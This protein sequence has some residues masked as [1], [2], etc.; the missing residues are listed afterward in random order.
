MK[1]QPQS[2]HPHGLSDKDFD[3]LFTNDKPIVFAFHGYPSLIHQ[4]TYRRTNHPNLHVR[5]YKEEGTTTT[6]F[7][8]TVMNDLDRFHLF[9]DVINR[10]PQLESHADR[11]RQF[12]RARLFDH[13]QYIEQHGEDMPE[14]R[15]WKWSTPP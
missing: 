11:A 6:P 1:L 12:I 15:N 9:G 14:I 5:G 3:V 2:E 4:L 13:K 7:D 10:L 8:M